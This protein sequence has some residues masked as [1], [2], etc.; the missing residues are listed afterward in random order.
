MI[1]FPCARRGKITNALVTRRFGYMDQLIGKF[2]GVTIGLAVLNALL[3]CGQQLACNGQLACSGQ[4]QC[5]ARHSEYC[6]L[7]STPWLPPDRLSRNGPK[8]ERTYKRKC[9]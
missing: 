2:A 5:T 9:A 1:S 8:R 6:K 7:E 3:K 4:T